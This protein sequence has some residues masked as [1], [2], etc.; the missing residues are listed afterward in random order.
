MVTVV[1]N[2]PLVTLVHHQVAAGGDIAEVPTARDV[3]A[4]RDDRV[5]AGRGKPDRDVVL[6]SV[7]DARAGGEREDEKE[8]PLH[9]S[10]PGRQL[11]AETDEGDPECQQATPGTYLIKKVKDPSSV[12]PCGDAGEVK[13]EVKDFD[14]SED[15]GSDCSV[16][17]DPATCAYTLRCE[18]TVDGMTLIT[19]V[20]SKRESATEI[21]G[22]VH[23][24]KKGFA[25]GNYDCKYTFTG[26]LQ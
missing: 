21:S 9:G 12:G 22:S 26:T 11:E 14:K 7:H 8:E 2:A 5:L 17:T 1:E 25:S 3:G 23:G 4:A 18:V 19:E 15:A 24:V 13:V 20:T 10:D 16:K 6:P